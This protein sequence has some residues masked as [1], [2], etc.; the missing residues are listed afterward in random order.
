MILIVFFL[1]QTLYKVQYHYYVN[2]SWYFVLGGEDVCED[3][4]KIWLE[5][6]GVMDNI[7]QSKQKKVLKFNLRP[8]H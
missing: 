5:E 4:E 2:V 6:D 8:K 1:L 3:G 7:R